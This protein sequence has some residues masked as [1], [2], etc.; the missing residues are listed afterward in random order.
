[1]KKILI[2]LALVLGLA[3]TSRAGFFTFFGNLPTVKASSSTNSPLVQ[4]G[5]FT[6]NGA[7]LL[8]SNGG[9]LIPTNITAIPMLTFDST[10][11][12]FFLFTQQVHPS[13][14]YATNN[15]GIIITNFT[16]P[17][18]GAVRIINSTNVDVTVSVSANIN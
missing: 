15:E 6:F 12:N 14:S 18:Y 8:L 7:T 5:S 9:T 4:V 2:I 11:T 1:M 10:G 13:Q 17:V 3:S 16:I